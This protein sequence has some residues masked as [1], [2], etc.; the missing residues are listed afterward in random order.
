MLNVL[1]ARTIHFQLVDKKDAEFIHNLR[2]DETYNSHLSKTVGDVE[3]Q[4]E[5]IKS[6]KLREAEKQELYYIIFRNDNNKRIGT[7][8]LYD[9]MSE[10]KSFCWGSWILNNDKTTSSAIE[11]ALLVY[12]VAFQELGFERCHFDVRKDNEK[13]IKFHQKLGAKIIK[14][15]E[16]DYYFNYEKQDYLACVHYFAKYLGA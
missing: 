12:K 15:T 10:K 16:L 14:T 4:R 13:V 3:Q 9:Y 1:K 2:K 7:V 6:Y 5:W 8:R 11:S